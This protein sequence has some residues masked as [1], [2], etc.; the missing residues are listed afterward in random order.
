M[1]KDLDNKKR[2]NIC[3]GGLIILALEEFRISIEHAI[4]ETLG[5]KDKREQTKKGD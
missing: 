1:K 5:L 4:M 2:N 3:S